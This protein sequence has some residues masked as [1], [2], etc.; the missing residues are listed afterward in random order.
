MIGDASLAAGAGLGLELVDQ[1]Y[2]GEEAAAGA[3]A[4][5]GPCDG[6][7]GVIVYR[8]RKRFCPMRRCGGG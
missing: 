6:D 1:V 7:A 3:A 4:D 5:A 8:E 2:D